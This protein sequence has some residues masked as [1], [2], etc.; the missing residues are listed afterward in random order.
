MGRPDSIIYPF[1]FKLQGYNA[2][3]ELRRIE[4][5]WY[6]TKI[7]ICKLENYTLVFFYFRLIL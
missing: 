2:K 3:A 7:R 6:T 4:A 1:A 5:K